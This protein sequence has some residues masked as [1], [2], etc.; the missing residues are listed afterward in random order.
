MDHRQPAPAPPRRLPGGGPRQGPAISRQ[1]R[2]HSSRARMTRTPISPAAGRI[3][4]RIGR[5]APG[6]RWE[7]D[8]REEGGTWW[9][10]RAS[11]LTLTQP[12]A[13]AGSA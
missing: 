12:Y 1:A 3:T 8:P 10:A 13:G 9:P 11:T 4:H 2:R 5:Q 7:I 6:S